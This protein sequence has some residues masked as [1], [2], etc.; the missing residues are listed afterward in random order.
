MSIFN[1]EGIEFTYPVYIDRDVNTD[2]TYSHKFPAIDNKGR[3]VERWA[4]KVRPIKD[5]T[6]LLRGVRLLKNRDYMVDYNKS[7]QKYEYWF[8]EG[9]MATLFTL[10]CGSLKQGYT[11][12][13]HQFDVG[14]PHCNAT[15]PTKDIIWR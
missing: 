3:V 2:P 13:G 8:L 5:L 4:K 7:T 11:P 10:A 9:Q 15:F 1:K 14:C 12:Q 6:N